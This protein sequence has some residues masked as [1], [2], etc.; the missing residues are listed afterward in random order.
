ME[1][2]GYNEIYFNGMQRS[3]PFSKKILLLKKYKQPNRNNK[4]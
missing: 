2:T 1:N 4:S 3:R